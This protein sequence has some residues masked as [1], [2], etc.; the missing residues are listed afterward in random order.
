MRLQR[1]AIPFL[2]VGV[3]LLAVVIA[4][5][6]N[7]WVSS[8]R[9]EVDRKVAS[10]TVAPEDIKGWMTLQDVARAF[11]LEPSAVARQAGLPA[12]F[13]LDRPLRE[14]ES[15][16]D[17]FEMDQVRDAVAE[18]LG[19]KGEEVALAEPAEEAKPSEPRREE[20]APLGSAK[21]APET[22]PAGAPAPAPSPGAPPAA[23]PPTPAAGKNESETGLPAAPDEIKGMNTL[24]EVV[25][26]F[27]VPADRLK[28]ESGLPADADENRPLRD[29]KSEIDGFEVE[30]VREAVRRLVQG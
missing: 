28:A 4:F 16:V 11:S 3:I 18:L 26:A 23:A 2:G 6:T 13:A 8:G 5:S 9:E 10:G 7:T 17:G 20:A 30:Q 25:K 19:G 1:A 15:E 21:K 24:A 27:D 22:R 12:D 29:F 14:A